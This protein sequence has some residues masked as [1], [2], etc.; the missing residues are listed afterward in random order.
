ML[1]LLANIPENVSKEEKATQVRS[2]DIVTPFISCINSDSKLCSLT[3]LSSFDML[4]SI[5]AVVSEYFPNLRTHKLSIK[6]RIIM[7]FM[8]LKTGLRYVCLASL[9]T[10][11]TGKTCKII[12][13][14]IISKL[15][16]V[17]RPLIVWPS[18]EECKS[19]LPKCFQNFK[20]VRVVL[21]CTELSVQKSSRLCCGILTYSHYKEA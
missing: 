18:A 12:F 8:K 17:L 9:F 19:N 4:G 3:G 20:N 16:V 11:V 6:E 10:T 14:D 2:G 5:V 15:A 13:H 1:L 21:D 7:T